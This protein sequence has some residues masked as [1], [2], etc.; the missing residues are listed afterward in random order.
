[1]QPINEL[2]FKIAFGGVFV[3]KGSSGGAGKG[4]A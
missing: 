3:M 4:Q 2:P 1:M